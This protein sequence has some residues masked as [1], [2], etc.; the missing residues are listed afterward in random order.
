MFV[1]S[2]RLLDVY[3]VG[4]P[5]HKNTLPLIRMAHETLACRNVRHV[6]IK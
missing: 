6:M 1:V 3:L 4:L 5:A 2:H